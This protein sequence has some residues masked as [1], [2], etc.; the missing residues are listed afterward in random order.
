VS[1]IKESSVGKKWLKAAH[2]V[3]LSI[4]KI[5]ETVANTILET[6]K[7]KTENATII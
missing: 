4:A 1:P 3:K 2:F 7:T 6:T 5:Q